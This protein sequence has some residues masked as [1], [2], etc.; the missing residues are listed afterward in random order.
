MGVENVL[1]TKA[2]SDLLTRQKEAIRQ[3]DFFA[4]SSLAVQME[5]HLAQLSRLPLG[6]GTAQLDRVKR[7]AEEN[8]RLLTAAVQGVQAASARLREITGVARE[9]KTYDSRGNRSLV[10]FVPGKMERHA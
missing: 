2:L 8:Q 3:G 10:S 7:Q 6:S 4:L 5:E 1:H 9:M